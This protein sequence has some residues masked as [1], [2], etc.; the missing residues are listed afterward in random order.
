MSIWAYLLLSFLCP[1]LGLIISK[2][3]LKGA[4]YFIL[5]TSFFALGS[6]IIIYPS[7]KIIL[8]YLFIILSVLGYFFSLLETYFVNRIYRVQF[9]KDPWLAT[10]LTYFF[11]PLGFWYQKRWF[12]GIVFVIVKSGHFYLFPEKSGILSIAIME[13]ITA[14]AFYLLLIYKNDFDKRL[15]LKFISFYLCLFFVLS[16]GILSFKKIFISNSRIIGNSMSPTFQDKDL[17]LIR[18]YK[19]LPKRCE[20]IAYKKDNRQCVGRVVAFEGERVFIKKGK[21]LVNDTVLDLS[22]DY[23]SLGDITV[24]KPYIVPQNCAFI[25]GDNSSNSYDSRYFGGVSKEDIQGKVYKIIYPLNRVKI[26]D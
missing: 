25:L 19:Y 11:L 5:T 26:F 21:I 13:I 22:F 9:G 3:Y 1:G 20:S 12:V 2:N 8:G 23:T 24:R 14:V 17:V 4:L 15:I 18:K 7:N 10:L 16:G 6:I